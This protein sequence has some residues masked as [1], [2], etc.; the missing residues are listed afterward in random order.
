MG[1]KNRYKKSKAKKRRSYESKFLEVVMTPDDT[2]PIIVNKETVNPIMENTMHQHLF[3][4]I[5]YP[6]FETKK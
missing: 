3:K 5:I 6:F 2:L 4:K 1:S